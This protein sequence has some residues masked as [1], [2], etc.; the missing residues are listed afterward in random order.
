MEQVI[1]SCFRNVEMVTPV[2]YLTSTITQGYGMKKKLSEQGLAYIAWWVYQLIQDSFDLSVNT[3]QNYSPV[4]KR[5]F[6][7][8]PR[9][10]FVRIF[11]NGD[12]NGGHNQNIEI[13]INPDS[14][15][16]KVWVDNALS[17]VRPECRHDF[18]LSVDKGHLSEDG[19]IERTVNI[20]EALELAHIWE[21]R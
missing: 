9:L 5:Y 2:E 8:A 16:A 6:D 17:L 3:R 21:D 20:E 7:V 18:E 11:V 14:K 19:S 10:N 1:T 15:T 4:D 13:I 12:N